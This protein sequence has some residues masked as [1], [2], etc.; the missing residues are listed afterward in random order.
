M[1]WLWQQQ[2]GATLVELM[3]GGAIAMLILGVI[4]QMQIAAWRYQAEDARRHQIQSEL[5][6][7]ADRLA[8]DARQASTFQVGANVVDL[9]VGGTT[10]TYAFDPDAGEITR[11]AGGTTRVL[12]QEVEALTFAVEADGRI[13]RAEMTARLPAGTPYTLTTRIALRSA[14]D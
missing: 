11:T 13:L 6:L 4:L 1:R 12:A 7:A 3:A 8:R 5:A 14:A 9:T 10:I 2:R